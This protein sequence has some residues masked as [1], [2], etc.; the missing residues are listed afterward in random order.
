MTRRAGVAY[1]IN[2]LSSVLLSAVLMLQVILLTYPVCLISTSVMARL[3][4]QKWVVSSGCGLQ[5]LVGCYILCRSDIDDGPDVL[6]WLDRMLIRLVRER[7]REFTVSYSVR[8]LVSTTKMI[9][10]HSGLQTTCHSIPGT[11]QVMC[12]SRDLTIHPLVR[13]PLEEVSVFASF[14]Q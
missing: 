2:P 5:W 14:Q 13:V 12:Q 3:A 9:P 10:A 7:E 8:S 1:S 6:R 11:M 4:V